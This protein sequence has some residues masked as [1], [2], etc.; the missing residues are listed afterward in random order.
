MQDKYCTRCKKVTATEYAGLVDELAAEIAAGRLKPGDR[1]LT[2]RAFAYERVS[3]LRR[4]AGSMPSSFGVGLSWAKL[5][6]APLLREVR[7]RQARSVASRATDASISSSI[8]RRLRLNS[9]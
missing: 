5:A 1:L 2:Q 4:R 9:R 3:P 8:F 6:V 7:R